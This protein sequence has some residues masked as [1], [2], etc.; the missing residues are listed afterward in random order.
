M[1]RAVDSKQLRP[2]IRT[3]YMR[4][5]FQ[6]TIAA[7]DPILQQSAD[8]HVSTRCLNRRGSTAAQQEMRCTE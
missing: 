8:A 7:A 4:T 1:Q 2:M 3:Q 5:A 6:V